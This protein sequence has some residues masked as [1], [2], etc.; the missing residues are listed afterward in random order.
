MPAVM[1]VLESHTGSSATL[2]DVYGWRSERLPQ[3]RVVET[4]P[5]VLY[6]ALARRKYSYA[7]SSSD[8]DAMLGEAIGAECRTSNDHEWDALL[9]AFAAASGI[10][11]RWTND[12]HA[13]PTGLGLKAYCTLWDNQLLL[14]RVGA[15]AGQLGNVTVMS[16]YRRKSS[17]LKVTIRVIPWTFIAATIRASCTLTPCTLCASRRAASTPSRPQQIPAA[18]RRSPPGERF[19]RVLPRWTSRVH[20][21]RRGGSQR[22]NTQRQSAV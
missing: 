13:L 19:H 22:S 10:Q 12:L 11:G 1:L 14:A 18:P 2:F 7:A 3:I 6:W 20:C 17:A 5:K 16:P 15:D 4:H 9:S 21:W 8:M